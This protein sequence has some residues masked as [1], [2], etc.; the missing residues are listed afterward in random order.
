MAAVLAARA[1]PMAAAA[2][3]AARSGSS[4]PPARQRHWPPLRR[5]GNGS[6]VHP[7]AP[8]DASASSPSTRAPQTQFQATPVALRVTGPS[9]VVNP[10]SPTVR[11]TS[12][13]GQLPPAVPQGGYGAIDVVLPAPGVTGV[14]VATS[15]VPSGTTVLVT[16]KPRIGGAALSATV[17]AQRVQHRRRV[18]GDDGIQSGRGRVFRRGARDVPGSVSAERSP[19][20]GIHAPAL[21][22]D[23]RR[24]H[25]SRIG[26][27]WRGHDGQRYC[28]GVRAGRV[29]G[30]ARRRRSGRARS[31]QGIGRE[32]PWKARRE[33]P[34]HAD[35][36]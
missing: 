28:P 6:T 26:V 16:V 7:L 20:A 4:P 18:H 19:G 11:I 2:D 21:L 32:E 17:P 29:R 8:P 15:G 25:S 1:A 5:A 27:D 36:A 14:D 35:R 31:S 13:N 33:E 22:Y 3:R 34:P 10:L 30:P 12:I 23:C 24:G 9:P